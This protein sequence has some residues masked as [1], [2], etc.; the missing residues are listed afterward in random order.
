[1]NP[2]FWR[3]VARVRG[4]KDC[5]KGWARIFGADFDAVRPLLRVCPGEYCTAYPDPQTGGR[6]NLS[7]YGDRWAAYRDPAA[8]DDGPDLEL[9]EADVLLYRLD[10]D[11]LRERVRTVLGVLGPSSGLDSGLDCLGTCTQGP[12]RRRVYWCQARSEA[13]ILTGVQDVIARAG[14]EGCAVFPTLSEA[15]DRMLAEAGVAGVQLTGNVSLTAAGAHG[16]C[17]IACRHVP[18][19]SRRGLRQHLDAR[20]D[21]VEKGVERV[22]AHVRELEAENA[23]LKQHLVDALVQVTRR[24]EPEFFQWVLMIL[25]K[26]SVRGVARELGLSDSTFDER[27][28]RYA[29]KSPLHQTLYSLVA[30]RRKGLGMKS[31]EGF[32][33][34]FPGHQRTEGKDETELL[35][36]VL[37]GLEALR[38][39]NFQTVVKELIELIRENLPGE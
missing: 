11:G 31:V 25:G 36:Q 28:K 29:R 14:A 34:M 27:L 13:E 37:D 7:R 26:G 15:A 12:K 19:L 17:G 39:G 2:D 22:G 1:M 33:E 6:L 10:G 23:L 20:L 18:D 38:P 8:E 35:R 9:T 24:V 5:L 30:V 4:R 21:R 32:N 3:L 16:G